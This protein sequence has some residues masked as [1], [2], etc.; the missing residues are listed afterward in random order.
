MRTKTLLCAAALAAG[1]AT[2]AVAQSNVYSLNVV[3]YYNVTVPANQ[4]LLVANQLNTT[5]NTLGG[6]LPS[7][8][9][10]SQF[11]VYSGGGLTPYV[12]DEFDLVWTPNGNAPL[13]PGQGGYFKSPVAT[14]LTFVGE[15]R[16]GSLTNVLPKN[17]YVI[18]ASIVPQSTNVVN[19]GVPG[20]P[21]DQ[22]QTYAGGFTPYVF[23]EFD[24]V[25]TPGDPNGPTIAVG[26]SFFYKKSPTGTQTNW[27][28]NF[29]VQ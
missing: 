14:T 2:S 21:G 7:V 11:Q 23:D 13:A 29:T 1:V 16:Q 17:A 15:V 3:G 25:W 6:V 9:P 26:Q 12:F 8:P 20:E 18:S 22:L 24:L 10:G 4:Y 5:N 28:R 19:L 27:I